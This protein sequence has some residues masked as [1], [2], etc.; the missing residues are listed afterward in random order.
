LGHVVAQAQSATDT[1]HHNQQ[2]FLP[3]PNRKLGLLKVS[4]HLSSQRT[5]V[6]GP[7]EVTYRT[8][9]P[10]R[11]KRTPTRGS[12]QTPTRGRQTPTVL[13]L[14]HIAKTGGTSVERWLEEMTKGVSKTRLSPRCLTRHN[15][16]TQTGTHCLSTYARPSWGA[17]TFCVLRDPVNRTFSSFN[18]NTH[19]PCEP[20]MVDRWFSDQSSHGTNNNEDLDQ[21][22]YLPFCEV[23]LCFERLQSD[24]DEMLDA[25]QKA[26]EK[27]AFKKSANNFST[28]LKTANSAVTATANAALSKGAMRSA[29]CKRS[30]VP[31]STAKAL[32][33]RYKADV[34]AH[35]AACAP[36]VNVREQVAAALMARGKAGAQALAAARRNA[37]LKSWSK[38][39]GGWGVDKH[40]GPR[41]PPWTDAQLEAHP[42]ATGDR[43]QCVGWKRHT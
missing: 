22:S 43:S 4:K 36:T 42:A 7:T 25:V 20:R 16:S 5:W 41:K 39:H 28:V 40:R 17:L 37:A 13:E 11:G 9:T 2:L 24:F 23:R 33:H 6:H 32:I 14:V 1:S 35:A 12:W 10:P 27:I 19:L 8:E 30:H 38:K 26:G 15:R 29:P 3:H 34:V 21:V 18:S 31:E